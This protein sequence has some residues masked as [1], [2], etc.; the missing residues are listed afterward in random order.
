[1]VARAGGPARH[2]RTYHSPE[3]KAAAAGGGGRR[4]SSWGSPGRGGGARP[5]GRGI[6]APARLP[7]GL[8]PTAG[9]RKRK[10]AP[11]GVRGGGASRPRTCPHVP[12][13]ARS[14]SARF[15][16]LLSPPSPT[17]IATG[18][19]PATRSGLPRTLPP[20]EKA[21]ARTVRSPPGCPAGRSAA[22]RTWACM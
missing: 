17:P 20:E 21:R 19:R 3:D 18:R 7:A 12:R 16:R 1:M 14:A 10:A 2:Q 8:L 15:P 6:C 4:H 11:R 5:A 13:T 9:P 22:R